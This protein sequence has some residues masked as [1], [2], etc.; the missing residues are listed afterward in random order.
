M[1][2]DAAT[3]PRL[4]VL[5]SGTVVPTGRRGTS[6]Y[7]VEDGR[8][9]RALVDLGPG[10]LHRAALAGCRLEALDAVLL[11]H[12]HPDHCA[13][14]VALRFALKNPSLGA[15]WPAGRA[16]IR[17]CG[18]PAVAQLTTRLMDAWPNWLDCPEQRLAF[19]AVSPGP[20][21]VPLAAEA[22]AFRI[23]HH[24]SS[25]GY[26]LAFA[27]GG[28][29]A[30]SGDADL[31]ADLEDLGRG[32][33]VFVL[34]AAVPDAASGRGHLSPRLAGRVAAASGVGHLVLTHFYPEVEREPI[35]AQVREAFEGKLTLAHDGMVL[36]LP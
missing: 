4:T 6:C 11:T 28:T 9:G 27:A 15:S 25:L 22:R 21:E 33:D 14:L 23:A 24:E 36:T 30:F 17:L 26:R 2:G 8:G 32:A 35:E 18:H 29:I 10:A 3:R 31:G 16:P 19:E 34:E 12:I 1:A 7:L 20:F 13:D 5:G